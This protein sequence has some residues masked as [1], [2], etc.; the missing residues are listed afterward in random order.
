MYQGV[1]GGG[2]V[3]G[4]GGGGSVGGVG[5]GG[6]R[7]VRSSTQNASVRPRGI[8]QSPSVWGRL[9]LYNG[10]SINSLGGSNTH[11]AKFAKTFLMPLIKGMTQPS[12]Q[13]AEGA[14]STPRTSFSKFL[15]DMFTQHNLALMSFVAGAVV[16]LCAFIP[17]SRSHFKGDGELTNCKLTYVFAF[18]ALLYFVLAGMHFKGMYDNMLPSC[19]EQVSIQYTMIG[20]FFSALFLLTHFVPRYQ[21]LTLQVPN[22]FWFIVAGYILIDISYRL[23]VPSKN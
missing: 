4:E 18:F 13:A 12:A 15:E 14:L 3:G 6:G 11:P 7:A 2:I 19:H 16:V 23:Y 5:D 10:M 1:Y 8:G 22:E 21:N 9:H 17:L 20:T